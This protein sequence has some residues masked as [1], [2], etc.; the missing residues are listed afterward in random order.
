MNVRPAPGRAWMRGIR[1]L[2]TIAALPVALSTSAAQAPA[3][4]PVDPRQEPFVLGRRL[5]IGAP[6]FGQYEIIGV[7]DSLIGD[8][9][10]LDT[11]LPR[12]R[13]GLFDGGTVPVEQFRRVRV[14]V[15][16]VRQAWVSNGVQRTGAVIRY[17]TFGALGGGLLFGISGSQQFNPTLR[18]VGRNAVPGAIIGG[19]LGAFIGAY[20]GRERWTLVPGPYY[21]DSPPVG[22]RTN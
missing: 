15:G 16:D 6:V 17:A 10:V 9:V 20:N 19:A 22:R 1:L 12:E 13:R 3:E 8:L 18:E 7:V 5:K 2:A 4:V 14:R 21:L 11:M